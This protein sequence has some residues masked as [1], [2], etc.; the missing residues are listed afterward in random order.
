MSLY[1]FSYN[2]QL[3]NSLMLSQIWKTVVYNVLITSIAMLVCYLECI[4]DT[5]L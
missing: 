4:K 3:N 5:I 2:I 1:C